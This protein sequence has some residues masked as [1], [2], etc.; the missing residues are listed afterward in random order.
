MNYKND[1]EKFLVDS[2]LTQ[3][4]GSYEKE[5]SLCVSFS[6]I[7]YIIDNFCR[8]NF[9]VIRCYEIIFGYF[10]YSIK[11]PYNIFPKNY[12]FL[13]KYIGLCYTTSR[14]IYGENT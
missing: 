2:Y 14:L 7:K 12:N 10:S 6:G 13:E 5:P 3:R 9:L 4:L 8:K 11:N 1:F